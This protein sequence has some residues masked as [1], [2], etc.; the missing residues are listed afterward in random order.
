MSCLHGIGGELFVVVRVINRKDTYIFQHPAH[1][2]I[3]M[4]FLCTA[5]K[6]SGQQPREFKSTGIFTG[7]E[8]GFINGNGGSSIDLVNGKEGLTVGDKFMQRRGSNMAFGMRSTIG[9]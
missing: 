3:A 7:R 6:E 5:T 1:E 4:Q 2:G 9:L 8:K